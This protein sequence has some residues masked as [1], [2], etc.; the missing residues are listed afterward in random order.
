MLHAL[1]THAKPEEYVSRTY[2]ILDGHSL[3]HLDKR[4]KAHIVPN[5]NTLIIWTRSTIRRSGAIR[6]PSN[7]ENYGF[8][9]THC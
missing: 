1:Y 2:L 4:S 8:R 5:R 3:D 9:L 6:I 7:T